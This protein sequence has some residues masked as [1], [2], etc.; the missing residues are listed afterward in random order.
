[1]H[2]PNASWGTW[3]GVDSSQFKGVV[4]NVLPQFEIKLLALGDAGQPDG[5]W[6]QVGRVNYFDLE[7]EY[8]QEACYFVPAILD[9]DISIEDRQVTLG[10]HDFVDF[11]NNT[12]AIKV[13]GR[14]S[15][16]LYTFTT[17]IGMVGQ[18]TLQ[19]HGFFQ[20]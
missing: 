14:G 2:S 1:L 8:I 13:P 7:G 17:Y 16:T 20:H 12:A 11:A 9:Y 10:A 5:A 18:R 6:L 4:L 19:A 15:L 3:K